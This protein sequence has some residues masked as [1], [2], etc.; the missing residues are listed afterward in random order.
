MHPL[1]L[2]HA[3]CAEGSLVD[4][5][6]DDF[7]QSAA[8]AWAYGNPVDP[9]AESEYLSCEDIAKMKLSMQELLN[10]TP[11]QVEKIQLL[12]IELDTTLNQMVCQ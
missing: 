10:L 4:L 2:P 7:L 8:I 9:V 5:L 12:S 6:W 11:A 3:A 1:S